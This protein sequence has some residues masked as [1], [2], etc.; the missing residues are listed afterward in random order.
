MNRVMQK[1]WICFLM[2]M[3]TVLG[4]P[5]MSHGQ[6]IFVEGQEITVQAIVAK[7]LEVTIHAADDTSFSTPLTWADMLPHGQALGVKVAFSRDLLAVEPLKHMV[8]VRVFTEDTE[9]NWRPVPV[10]TENAKIVGNELR[11][12]LSWIRS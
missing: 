9:T 7:V 10:D 2:G 6:I 11:I 12:T 3:L 4:I 8:E 5:C 1:R